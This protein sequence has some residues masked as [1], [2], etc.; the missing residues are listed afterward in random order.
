MFF[1]LFIILL[2]CGES[3]IKKVSEVKEQNK[4]Q[5][6][7]DTVIIRVV[8]SNDEAVDTSFKYFEERILNEDDVPDNLVKKF[9]NITNTL[10][11]SNVKY[12][13][14]GVSYNKA[15]KLFYLKGGNK[16]SG[17]AVLITYNGSNRQI[18]SKI[19]LLYCKNCPNDVKF[20]DISF[21]TGGKNINFIVKY[22]NPLS[23]GVMPL[24]EEMKEKREEYWHINKNGIFEKNK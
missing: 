21:K 18:D 10:I 9:V 8:S 22:F 1:P 24:E 13:G 20:S 14:K 11:S 5:I 15:Y 17:Q 16:D 19:F 23:T 4:K 6:A 7:K 12:I 3:Q 2:G